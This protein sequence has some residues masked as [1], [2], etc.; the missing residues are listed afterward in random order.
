MSCMK[1]APCPCRLE[2]VLLFYRLLPSCCIYTSR[3]RSSFANDDNDDDGLS[4]NYNNDG[5]DDSD[6]SD[7]LAINV[8][9]TP[10]E[11]HPAANSPRPLSSRELPV[12]VRPRQR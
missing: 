8:P 2:L 5:D 6:D 11:A 4:D 10:P 9:P 7:Q 3:P 1:C 12:L